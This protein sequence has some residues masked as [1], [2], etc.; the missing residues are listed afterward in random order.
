MMCDKSEILLGEISLIYFI[1]MHPLKRGRSSVA[2]G[3]SVSDALI[4]IE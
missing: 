2:R 4:I 3:K 1:F